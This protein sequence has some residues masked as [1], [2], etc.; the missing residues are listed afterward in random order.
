MQTVRHVLKIEWK[1]TY[2]SAR[3]DGWSRHYSFSLFLVQFLYG[4][5]EIVEEREEKR[6]E[7]KRIR[8]NA[9]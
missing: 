9:R 1:Y 8:N 7:R 2:K 3:R 5:V 4:L 6:R